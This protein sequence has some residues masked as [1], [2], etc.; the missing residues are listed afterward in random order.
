[1]NSCKINFKEN[2]F[3]LDKPPDIDSNHDIFYESRELV[4]NFN[5]LVVNLNSRK[6]F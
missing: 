4:D 1:M 3:K 2:E 5:K 6:M